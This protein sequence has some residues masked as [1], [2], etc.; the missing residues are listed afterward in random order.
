V[1]YA[2]LLLSA[3]GA[4]SGACG[5][6]AGPTSPPGPHANYYVDASA[7]N[8]GNPGDSAQPFKTVQQAAAVVNPGDVVV[9]RNG[10]YTGG[11]NA[12][13]SIDRGG[14]AASWVVFTTATKWGAILDG[15]GGLGAQGVSDAG[16]SVNA[17][18]V[19][20][21]GFDI[22]WV[23][24]DAFSV[25]VDNVQIAGNHIHD[26]GRYCTDD[27]FGIAGYAGHSGNI[28][29]EQNVVH[30]VGR[31]GPGEAG[32]SPSTDYWQNHDHGI[33]HSQGNNFIVRNNVFYNMTHGWPIQLYAGSVDQFYVVNNTFAFANPNR[34]GHIV[35]DEPLSN[36]VIA[37]NI[38]YQPTTAGVDMSG[39]TLTNV[40]VENN[41][42]ANG[43][44]WNGSATGATFA[45]NFDN[46]DPKFVNPAA[47][48][49]HL[50]AGSPAIGAGISL[51]YV[52]TDFDGVQRPQGTGW[53]IG[54]FE[55]H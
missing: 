9:V 47:F 7:G 27:S 6:S 52:P 29:F 3:V 33:Y 53:D 25:N 31:L 49:F 2:T 24:H 18:Y 17:S 10:T 21:E 13:L 32:C 44:V 16:V 28:V 15:Q 34:V 39:G 12:V 30:D 1:R 37:N 43:V 51:S 5:S 48:D 8:D 50:Q 4:L 11:S 20:I 46:T 35:I 19:R 40:T 55:F 22:R 23:Y 38:F 14:T 54:A 26:I 41:I 45:N 36:S 42:T